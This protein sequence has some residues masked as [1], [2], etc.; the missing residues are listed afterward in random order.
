MTS[1]NVLLADDQLLFRKGMLALLNE[2]PGINVIAEAKDGIELMDK[3]VTATVL[4]DVILLDLNMPGMNGID[5]TVLIHKQYPGIRIIILS[6][7]DDVSFIS[8][9]LENGASGY[10]V[11]NA[12]PE[13]VEKAIREVM[14]SGFYFNEHI[15]ATLQKKAAA[16]K[17]KTVFTSFN[18]SISGRELDVLKLICKEHTA[19]EIAEKLYISIRTVDGHRQKL[20]DKT[21]ARNTAGLVLFAVKNQLVELDL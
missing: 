10:L 17:K 2:C 13:E 14:R 5:A 8:N 19:N 18:A 21:G 12:E 3:L 20:L 15:L 7:Y 4:P 11:K 9:V 16:K 6:I 1:I